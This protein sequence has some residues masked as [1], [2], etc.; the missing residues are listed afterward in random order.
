MD[1]TLKVH[2]T[3]AAALCKA[4]LVSQAVGE[5]AKLQGIMGRAYAL[6]AG[7]TPEVAAAIEEHYRPTQS[8]GRL[9][10][11]LP[12]ALVAMADKIDTICGCFHVGL[13]P[14]GAADPYALRR[15]SVGIVQIMLDK[16][17]QI[18]LTDLIETSLKLYQDA[19]EDNTE[20]AGKIRDFFKGR[21]SNLLQED[22]YSKEVIASVTEIS[23]DHVPNIWSRTAA[24]EALKTRPDF[25]PLA[26][27]FKRVVN[28]IKKADPAEG[29][30]IDESLFEDPSEAA[31]FS[32]FNLVKKQVLQNLDQGTFDQALLGI[33]S[34]RPAVDA[35]F[36]GVLVMAE[37]DRVRNNRLG[38]LRAIADLFALVAD[39]SKM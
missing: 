28:I 4:D 16:K 32:E 5:F 6:A 15:Q 23:V 37:D 38:L 24:L 1:E 11:S 22:G 20:T 18:P 27:A 30:N 7:E 2:A 17:I 9:P 26:V 13:I 14:T 39:F 34:L 36:D 33:A 21:I 3:R 35:F 31:L 25:E 12:G 10:E 29:L 8:G 19:A